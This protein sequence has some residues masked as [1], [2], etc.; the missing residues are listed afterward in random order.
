MRNNDNAAKNE[1]PFWKSGRVCWKLGH[2]FGSSLGGFDVSYFSNQAP[3]RVSPLTLQYSIGWFALAGRLPTNKT[4]A[5]RAINPTF[6][7]VFINKVVRISVF[8]RRLIVTAHWI[9]RREMQN[10]TFLVQGQ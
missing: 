9:C 6:T 3:G 5:T 4:P 2:F 8:P 7:V 1:R 10:L